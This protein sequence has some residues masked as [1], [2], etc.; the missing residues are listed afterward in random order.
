MKPHYS[1]KQ[2]RGLMQVNA[3]LK[4]GPV[5]TPGPGHLSGTKHS[6]AWVD[7]GYVLNPDFYTYHAAYK[8]I[9]MARA[10]VTST[11][12]ECWITPPTVDDDAF[13]EFAERVSLWSAM[14]EV[15][16]MQRVG[17]YAG[18]IMRV[19]D[20]RKLSDP[21]VSADLDDIVQLMPAWEGQLTPGELDNNPNS[22]TYGLPL[23]YNYN[24]GAV[25]S[26][27]AQDG[28]ESFIVHHSRVLIWNEGA[29]GNTI[30][31]Q[32][33][34]EPVLNAL[35]DWEKLRGAAGEGF[36]RQ[37][38]L[39]A[40]IEAKEGVAAPSAD[41]MDDLLETISDMH[42]SF[43]AIPYLGGASLN[44]LQTTLST[45]DGFIK[46]I[47]DDIAAGSGR[48]AKSL[49]GAQEGRLAGESDTSK[50]ARA[51]QSRRENYLTGQVRKMINRLMDI[52]ALNRKK[53]TIEWDSLLEPSLTQKIEIAERMG[54]T[55]VMGVP[56]FS[57][58]EIRDVAGYEPEG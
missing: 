35:F 34:L 9:G 48:S 10:V 11:V 54:K 24:Q 30:Y 27:H 52:G 43:D 18:L 36:W 47:I 14:K 55:S 50:D 40:V 17:H 5:Y 31:G 4:R 13:M 19:A 46:A 56:V 53:Y 45:P 1:S 6:K 33:A 26:G 7:Y 37:A 21:L 39:R 23:T 51:D 29:H 44:T 25:T 49:I 2:M 22:M 20:D 15:D 57:V 16:E 12:D 28:N 42:S 3:R 58:D 38:S 32:S 41:D 8:R